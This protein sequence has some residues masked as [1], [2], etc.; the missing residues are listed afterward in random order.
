[1]REARSQGGIAW[2]SLEPAATEELQRL[3]DVLKLHPL[4]VRDSL[5]GH[6][7][8]KLE[9]YDELLFVVLQPARYFDDRETVEC[10]KSICSSAPT[11]S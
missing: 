4:A 5:K 11:T 9:R 2:I 6:Q 3:A 1:M 8:S 10:S 7:R